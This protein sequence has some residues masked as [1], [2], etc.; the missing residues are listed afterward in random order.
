MD[1]S[2]NLWSLRL[3]INEAK[4]V[5]YIITCPFIEFFLDILYLLHIHLINTCLMCASHLDISAFWSL[6][7]F[8]DSVLL[9]RTWSLQF[10]LSGS[11][12]WWPSLV[13]VS[14]LGSLEELTPRRARRMDILCPMETAC[15]KKL[16]PS[17]A[18][19]DGVYKDIL[20]MCVFGGVG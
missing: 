18:R 9:N 2:S 5:N 3:W 6:F 13:F 16:G 1:R 14:P 10:V 11:F 4:G 19:Y 17:V 7:F 20:Y 8:L 15:L 12:L